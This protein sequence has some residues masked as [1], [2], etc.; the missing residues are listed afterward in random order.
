MMPCMKATKHLD[1][2]TIGVPTD[3]AANSENTTTAIS[4]GQGSSKS[5]LAPHVR[6]EF[7]RLPS[8]G[9]DPFFGLTRSYYYAA[10]SAGLLRLV[11]LRK[12]GKT[13]GI[14]LVPYEKIAALIHAAQQESSAK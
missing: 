1:R 9:G 11:R 5:N 10:E 3:E 6:P 12:R 7:Y 14:T 2:T 8:K 4:D 13:R